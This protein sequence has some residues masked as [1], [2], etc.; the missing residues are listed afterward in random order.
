MPELPEVETTRR[1]IAPALTG[2]RILAAVVRDG[3]LRWPVAP[4]LGLR[5]RHQ[6]VR[7]VG[8]RAKY[9]LLCCTDGTLIIHLGM[10]G[11]LRLVPEG[12]PP[13]PHD[14]VDIL[15]EGG[16]TLRLH[17][18]RRFGSVHWTADPPEHHP[19]LRD[20]GPE[21]LDAD[22][23]GAY[24]YRRS[25]GRHGA[26]KTLLM[27]SHTV[28]GVG[29]IY[30]NEALY[31]AGI[32]P[33][34]PAG[35]ISARRYDGLAQAIKA[36]LAQAIRAGGTTLR[37]F[38]ASDGR[39]GYFSLQ[40]QVYGRVGLPCLGCEEPIRQLRQGQRATYYCPHCQR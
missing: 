9:L 25:R 28:A 14:H 21:P 19:L 24:L 10:S 37:D 7:E 4:D 15:L 27:D 2:R 18:P 29:N 22:F 38:Y 3:R 26:V 23:D 30:A 20:L 33:T 6:R 5:L 1:G 36:V 31:S 40:L 17:D 39:P 8:R 35:R 11:N 16:L 12:V 32:R 13:Q 34:R